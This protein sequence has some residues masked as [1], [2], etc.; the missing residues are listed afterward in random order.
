[1]AYC[2]K[3]G[4]HV[5]E[6]MQFCPCCGEKIP[7]QSGQTYR[8]P[9]QNQNTYQ[10]QNAYQNQNVYQ[11]FYRPET[12]EYYDEREVKDNK[13]MGVLSYLGILLLIPALA[14]NK[15]SKYVRHHLNQG[16]VLQIISIIINVLDG[17][18]VWR[19]HGWFTIMGGIWSLAFDIA[20]LA[21]FV[22]M[23]LGIV[24][25]CRGDKKKLPILGEFQIIK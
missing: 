10:N 8:D 11:S 4:T 20:K 25:A 7:E 12:E 9:Y 21:C 18:L 15:Q 14:G 13:V 16:L 24:S 23:I 2:V 3:C 19:M 22:F 6:G 17:S 1:M 5:E